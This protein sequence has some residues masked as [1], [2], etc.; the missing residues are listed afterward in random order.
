MKDVEYLDLLEQSLIRAFKEF[1]PDFIIFNAG[2]D[3]L[4]GDS[5]GCLDISPKGVISR[6]ELVFR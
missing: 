2:T 4:Q 6:D 3:I 5:L 1:S